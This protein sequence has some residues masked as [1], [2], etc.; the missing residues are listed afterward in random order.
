MAN[1]FKSGTECVAALRQITSSSQLLS[2]EKHVYAD[3]L[4]ECVPFVSCMSASELSQF[5]KSIL[6]INK[7]FRLNQNNYLFKSVNSRIIELSVDAES[8]HALV[9]AVN[10][11]SQVT[12]APNDGGPPVLRHEVVLRWARSDVWNIISSSS[13]FDRCE[14]LSVLSRLNMRPPDAFQ[15][16]RMVED[17]KLSDDRVKA[18]GRIC[19][20]ILALAKLGYSNSSLFSSLLE[21]IPSRI[22]ELNLRELSNLF[23][24]VSFPAVL[25]EEEFEK[26]TDL[27]HALV[28]RL[29]RKKEKISKS[30]MNQIGVA[31][32]GFVSTSHFDK[33]F[34]SDHLRRFSQS[35]VKQVQGEK[36]NR[37]TSSKAQKVVKEAIAKLGIGDSFS[38]ELAIGPYRIDLA[39]LPRSLLIEING[40]FH[41]YYKSSELTA[42]SIF[43]R[44]VLQKLGF[45][46]MEIDFMELKDQRD[47]VRLMDEKIRSLLE[48]ENPNRSL[49][50]EFKF[51]S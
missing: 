42:K 50:S 8:N 17:L 31:S 32:F 39:C 36:E 9:S 12:R 40:P 44:K 11:L 21:L 2:R 37:I 46:V 24:A 4:S 26:W 34:K 1:L 33:V 35:T 20:A 47:R 15:D 49:K 38:E 14:M 29:E 5:S 28:C 25:H 43:K 10:S 18:K 23:Y 3:L 27:A 16:P 51:L 41:Y 7:K 22:E 6:V 48:M 13:A 45:K 30:S 19:G